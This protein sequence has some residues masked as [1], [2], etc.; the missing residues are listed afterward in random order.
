M[1]FNSH[2]LAVK[3]FIP[4]SLTL[5]LLTLIQAFALVKGFL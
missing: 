3:G 1:T 2:H 5:V 4:F